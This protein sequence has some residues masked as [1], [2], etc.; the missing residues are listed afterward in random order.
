MTLVG[1][2]RTSLGMITHDLV[3][4]D[5]TFISF[6]VFALSTLQFAAHTTVFK[7]SIKSNLA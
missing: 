7:V 2:Y 3:K 1:K 5:L 4:F 6:N